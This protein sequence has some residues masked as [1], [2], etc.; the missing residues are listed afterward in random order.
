MDELIEKK[1]EEASQR[2]L[3]HGET[4][5]PLMRDAI[6]GILAAAALRLV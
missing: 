3:E 1:C 2:C 4:P 6:R 5:S